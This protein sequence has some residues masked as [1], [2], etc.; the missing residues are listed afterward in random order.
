MTA[1]LR[2]RLIAAAETL[3]LTPAASA[4]YGALVYERRVGEQFSLTIFGAQDRIGARRAAP[5]A[6]RD[7]A[8]AAL[9][10]IEAHGLAS[11]ERCQGVNGYRWGH[12]SYYHYTVHAAAGAGADA[13]AWR[14]ADTAF[15]RLSGTQ[16]AADIGPVARRLYVRLAIAFGED[17]RQIV[18]QKELGRLAGMDRKTALKHLTTTLVEVGLAIVTRRA[19]PR[20]NRPDVFDVELIVAVDGP[21]TARPA[22]CG[23]DPNQPCPE[24]EIELDAEPTPPR[25]PEQHA[26]RPAGVDSPRRDEADAAREAFAALWGPCKRPL[27]AC[28]KR[29]ERHLDEG[30]S[31]TPRDLHRWFIGPVLALQK[32]HVI[33]SDPDAL[34]KALKTTSEYKGGPVHATDGRGH[35]RFAKFLRK[36]ALREARERAGRPRPGS[37]AVVATTLRDHE[38]AMRALVRAASTAFGADDGRSGRGEQILDEILAKADTVADLFAGDL[39]YTECKLREAVKQGNTD[40]VS[41]EPFPWGLDYTPEWT[42]PDD[43]PVEGPVTN[44]DPSLPGGSAHDLPSPTHPDRAHNERRHVSA[45]QSRS[46]PTF[47][48]TMPET[49]PAERTTAADDSMRRG[50]ARD[51]PSPHHV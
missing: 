8:I 34:Y 9:Q 28:W 22:R 42:W 51:L 47:T 41:A 14:H 16:L 25:I 30:T 20:P 24:I 10:A 49:T 44:A 38:H 45:G 33:G 19:S 5:R 1:P 18:T 31:F 35:E 12:G 27:T 11:R 15:E 50:P 3:D 21:L 13:V 48:H 43:I 2:P 6:K 4:I 23:D 40:F 29:A 26:A 46:R 39:A 36:V 17:G 7:V 32:E 37:N